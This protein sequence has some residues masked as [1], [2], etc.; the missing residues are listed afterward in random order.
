MT[1]RQLADTLAR[2]GAALDAELELLRHVQR[3]S[4]DQHEATTRHDRER[5]HHVASERIRL[6]D[7]LV[8]IE[9]EIHTDR[10]VLADH[11]LDAADLPGFSEVAGLHRTAA[12]LIAEI[13]ATDED[14][15]AALQ[16]AEVVRRADAQAID[17][18]ETTL[19]AYRRVLAPSAHGPALVDRHG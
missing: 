8:R 17:A 5:L 4:T 9:H 1:R 13:A 12:A 2:Y 18:G 10:T 7:G 11:R 15:M 16:Q 3:L 14:T 19:N 6:M